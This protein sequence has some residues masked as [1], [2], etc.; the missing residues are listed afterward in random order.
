MATPENY[1]KGH[2]LPFVAKEE[3]AIQP[4]DND[5]SVFEAYSLVA[6]LRCDRRVMKQKLRGWTGGKS[7]SNIG[8]LGIFH[9]LPSLDYQHQ[10]AT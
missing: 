9:E 5:T 6:F 4:G 1:G 10:N 7:K 3:G 2:F 8:C